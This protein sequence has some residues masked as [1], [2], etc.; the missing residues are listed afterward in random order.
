MLF[1]L[2]KCKKGFTLIE[3]IIVIAVV[4]ILA[5]VAIPS[6][7]EVLDRAHAS[8]CLSNRHNIELMFAVEDIQDS[9]LDLQ[10]Y[11]DTVSHEFHCPTKGIYTADENGCVVCS[12]HTNGANEPEPPITEEKLLQGNRKDYTNTIINS[13]GTTS[14][15]EPS[16]YVQGSSHNIGDYVIGADDLIYECIK[17]LRQSNDPTKDPYGWRVVGSADCSAV[18]IDGTWRTYK[19]GTTVKKGTKYYMYTPVLSGDFIDTYLLWSGPNDSA[20]WTDVTNATAGEYVKPQKDTILYKTYTA[21]KQGDV[22]WHGGKLYKAHSDATNT[23]GR[24]PTGGAW[25]WN[26]VK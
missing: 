14:E 23:D 20:D 24:T 6:F 26:L 22:V 5:C 9:D 10:E 25:G 15:V 13:D 2:I 16:D 1:N 8:T 19:P 17:N 11:L 7:I 3:L 21:Y 18:E 4:A 12:V